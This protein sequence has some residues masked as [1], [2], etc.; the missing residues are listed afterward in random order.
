LGVARTRPP[1]TDRMQVPFFFVFLAGPWAPTGGRLP[2]PTTPGWGL[3][4]PTRGGGHRGQPWPR[5]ENLTPDRAHAFGIEFCSVRHGRRRWTEHV[6]RIPD[7]SGTFPSGK[8]MAPVGGRRMITPSYERSRAWP[9]DR[10]GEGLAAGPG[11]RQPRG[12]RDWAD[13]LQKDNEGDGGNSYQ[14]PHE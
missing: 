7:L 11:A 13:V 14:S 9:V 4:L 12:T 10:P 8:M 1:G 6:G 3:R 2:P 5:Q